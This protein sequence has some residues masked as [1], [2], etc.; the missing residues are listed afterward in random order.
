[1]GEKGGL[2][3][4][5]QWETGREPD[6]QNGRAV[7]GKSELKKEGAPGQIENSDGEGGSRTRERIRNKHERLN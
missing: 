3:K 5:H 4:E 1:M 2:G 6:H 7:G